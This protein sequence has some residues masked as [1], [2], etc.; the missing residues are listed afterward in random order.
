[1]D[2]HLDAPVTASRAL[3]ADA[4]GELYVLGHDGDTLSVDGAQVGVLKKANQVG[5]REG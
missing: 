5:L 1:M 2:A 4:A 3:T